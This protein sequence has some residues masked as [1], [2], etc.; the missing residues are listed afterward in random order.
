M[1]GAT[2]TEIHMLVRMLNGR[3]F[4]HV[5]GNCNAALFLIRNE[6]FFLQPDVVLY[7]FDTNRV[8]AQR[9]VMKGSG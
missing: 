6:S 2:P 4:S 7:V 3:T 5:L 1:D 9:V 8:N